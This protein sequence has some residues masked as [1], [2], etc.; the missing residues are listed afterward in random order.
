MGLTVFLTVVIAW[1]RTGAR[2]GLR[3]LVPVR[4]P[5]DAAAPVAAEV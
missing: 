5:A 3:F 1:Q 4:R 2:H